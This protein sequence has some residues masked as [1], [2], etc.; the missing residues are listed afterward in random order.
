MWW[1]RRVYAN[2][3]P[4]WSKCVYLVLG[5]VNQFGS[6]KHPLGATF[7]RSTD[8][9]YLDYGEHTLVWG[10]DIGNRC[11]GFFSNCKSPGM[12]DCEFINGRCR[13]CGYETVIVGLRRNC[14]VRSGTPVLLARFERGCGTACDLLCLRTQPVLRKCVPSRECC[15]AGS[16]NLSAGEVAAIWAGHRETTPR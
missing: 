1:N 5:A 8:N 7:Q 10:S 14:P 13:F 11:S 6:W 12:R 15:A 9:C 3:N 4:K 16:V 2:D